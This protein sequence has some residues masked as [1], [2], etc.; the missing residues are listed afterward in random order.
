MKSFLTHIVA[1]CG[2]LLAISCGE[3]RTYQYEEKTQHNHWMLEMMQDKYLWADTLVNY[4]PAWKTFFSTP[5]D[6]LAD[7]TKRTGQADSWSYIE[8]DTLTSDSHSRGYFSHVESY[9]MDFVLM[10]D[11]TGQTTKQMLRVLTVYS[12][13]PAERAGLLRGDFIS[14]YDGYKIS[15]NNISKLQKGVA[16]SLE[17]CHMAV[18]ET[19]GTFYWEDTVTVSM[20]ASEYVEDKAFPVSDIVNA[21]GT[22]VGYLMCTRLLDTPTEKGVASAGSTVYRDELDRIMAQM[23]NAGVAEMVLDLRLCNDG[24]LEMAQHLASYVVNPASLHST[25]AKTFWN[26]AYSANNQSLPYDV[27]VANLGLSRV[28]VLVSSYTQGAAE[29]LIHSL[30]YS[31]GEENVILIGQSTKGQNVMTEEVGSQYYVH[32]FPVVAYVADGDGNYDYGSMSPTVEVDEQA[33]L[34]L[35]DYGSPSEILFYTSIQH[36]LGLI[37]QNVSE[38]TGESDNSAENGTGEGENA[39][40]ST[41]ESSV[42]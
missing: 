27:S 38:N 10:T 29:W 5:G 31:M 24:T 12:G 1:I 3:D 11:P 37:S 22:L 21:E 25:F 35:A 17:V 19:E 34:T 41:E 7:L 32:L 16:R 4:E 18:D 9:G 36:I 23:K 39:D 13:S 14:A 28:Y 8:I 2:V 33:Y 20:S 30:Q 42:E 40:E 26:E 6:F 15:S